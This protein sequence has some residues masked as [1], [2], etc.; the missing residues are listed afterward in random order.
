MDLKH[1]GHQVPHIFVGADATLLD[2]VPAP[3]VKRGTLEVTIVGDEFTSLCPATGGPDFGTITITYYPGKWL[4]ES[5]SLKLY[6]ESYRQEGIFH[7]A[8]VNQVG[9]HLVDLLEP[10]SIS[11]TGNFKPRGGWAIVPTFAWYAGEDD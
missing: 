5:K 3:E 10:V 8:I 4:V 1:L 9:N 7:E 2:R 6:L 11:V